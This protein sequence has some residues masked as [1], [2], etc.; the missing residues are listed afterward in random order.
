MSSR[1]R[2]IP[3]PP[4]RFPPVPGWARPKDVQ[5]SAADA[6]FAAGAALA[7]LHPIARDEHL[8]GTLWRQR[9]AL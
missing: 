8:L 2:I 7:A 9:L 5:N 1:A 6:L 3:E 4:R